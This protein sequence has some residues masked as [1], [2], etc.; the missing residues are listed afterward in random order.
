MGNSRYSAE[1]RK[2]NQDAH[3]ARMAQFEKSEAGARARR[4]QT[5]EP[6]GKPESKSEAAEQQAHEQDAAAQ[7]DERAM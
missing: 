2:A 3:E 6:L 1:D 7:P 4:E 5:G